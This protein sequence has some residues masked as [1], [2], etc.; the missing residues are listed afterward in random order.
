MT[1]DKTWYDF[2]LLN[3][4]EDKYLGY[5][6]IIILDDFDYDEWSLAVDVVARRI[7]DETKPRL[8][9]GE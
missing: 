6:P 9:G 3:T 7:L 4:P 2:A 1:E 5:S 8:A